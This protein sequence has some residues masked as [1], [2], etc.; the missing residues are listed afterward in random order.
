M[1]KELK[2]IYTDNLKTNIKVK[3]MIIK[4]EKLVKEKYNRAKKKEED[5]RLAEKYMNER[6]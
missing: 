4:P 6:E 1:S 2:V 5:R 3:A